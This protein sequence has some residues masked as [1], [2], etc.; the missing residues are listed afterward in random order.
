[1]YLTIYYSLQ[2]VSAG[3][4]ISVAFRTQQ[5]INISILRTGPFTY[6]QYILSTKS[7]FNVFRTWSQSSHKYKSKS[8]TELLTNKG[9][10][11][12]INYQLALHIYYNSK[13]STNLHSRKKKFETKTVLH[14]I[15]SK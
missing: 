5:S 14:K 8:P 15:L 7:H 13:P 9:N 12:A 11:Q 6:I 4:A 10:S 1:M 2:H 3:L